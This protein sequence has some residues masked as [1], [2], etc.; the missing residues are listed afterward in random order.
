[1]FGDTTCPDCQQTTTGDCGRHKPPADA[2]WRPGV[3]WP[4]AQ[5]HKCPVCD[6]SG[7]VSRPPHIAG[8]VPTWDSYGTA[9]YPCRACTGQGVLWG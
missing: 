1:M 5:P 6:G 8:D 9:T 4:G 2:A 7:L 3:Y